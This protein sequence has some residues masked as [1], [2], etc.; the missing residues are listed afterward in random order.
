MPVIIVETFLTWIRGEIGYV[1]LYE[2]LHKV[3]NIR[4]IKVLSHETMPIPVIVCRG[5]EIQHLKV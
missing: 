5:P 4:Q 3:K 1:S 2:R